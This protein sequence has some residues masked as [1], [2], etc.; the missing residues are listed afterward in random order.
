MSANVSVNVRSALAV[1]LLCAAAGRL[2]PAAPIPLTNATATFSQTGFTAPAAID[3]TTSGQNGW[4]VYDDTLPPAGD[5]TLP[6]KWVAQATTPFGGVSQIQHLT[7]SM[8]QNFPGNGLYAEELGRF[9][10]W[11][12]NVANPTSSSIEGIW[13]VLAPLTATANIA[14]LAIQG[15]NSIKAGGTASLN[16]GELYTITADTTL[17]GVTGFRVE[18]M[19]DASFPFNGPGRAY[20]GNFVLTEFSVSNVAESVPEPS[21]IVTT[22]IGAAACASRRRRQSA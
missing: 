19:A 8:V 13:T 9:R 5:T 7:I 2:A 15:D 18:A 10:L 6:Q 14:T 3:G 4:G 20:D 1:A 22:M 21:S 12:T 17:V 11:V 16:G